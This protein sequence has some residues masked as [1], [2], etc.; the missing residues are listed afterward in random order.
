MADATRSQDPLS[1][2]R[3]TLAELGVRPGGVLM[4]HASLRGSGL[5]P[6]AVRDALLSALGPG[7]TLV[8]PAFTP[9]NSDTSREYADRTEG[10]DEP[11]KAGFRASMPPFDPES[12]PCPT[13]GALA[14][15][16]RT[17]PG[18]VRSGHP[19]T[20]FAALGP[21]ATELLGDHDPHCHLG[22]RSPLSEL[23]EAD[24]EILLLRV[25]FEVCTAFH[26][27]E[28]RLS[29]PPPTRTYRCV[30]RDRGWIEYEDVD[31]YD[32]DF[33]EIGERLPRD[34]RTEREVAGRT[35]VLI[36]M[37]DAVDTALK[38]MSGYRWEMT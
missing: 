4:A 20:S 1:R 5:S 8:V 29:P 9:E 21:R 38:Q 2:F 33:E 24:A 34:L 19:Q 37:R 22:E 28:Y 3:A 23:Y 13:M 32:G 30:V 26:L 31:L 11:Q 14:E 18:A 16:V 27:A 17:T 6:T 10:M 25:G 15:C 35:T 12:T 7:G 36:G